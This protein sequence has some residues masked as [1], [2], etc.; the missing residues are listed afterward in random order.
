MEFTCLKRWCSIIYTYR[1]VSQLKIPPFLLFE[2]LFLFPCSSTLS[3]PN[4]RSWPAHR[5]TLT[6]HISSLCKPNT[7][8]IPRHL[9]KI[10]SYW[11]LE[12]FKTFITSQ[13]EN[14]NYQKLYTKYI[15]FCTTQ[16]MNNS[17]SYHFILPKSQS[18]TTIQDRETHHRIKY[19]EIRKF[20]RVSSNNF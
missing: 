8:A 19:W 6:H 10:L 1:H 5:L 7:L 11:N 18:M 14:F 20:P 15:L 16:E 4:L 13:N 3:R 17:N 9:S 12:V 2:A